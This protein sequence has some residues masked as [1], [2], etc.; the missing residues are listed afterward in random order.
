MSCSTIHIIRNSRNGVTLRESG[1]LAGCK[2][3]RL[4]TFLKTLGTAR[5]DPCDPKILAV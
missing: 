2:L 3:S 4:W 5:H 1:D